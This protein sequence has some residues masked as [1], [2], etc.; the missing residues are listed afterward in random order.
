MIVGITGMYASGKDIVAAYLVEQGFE[1]FSLSDEIREEATRLGIKKT[2]D[3]LISLGNKL[4]EAF[5]PGILAERVCLKMWPGQKYV[6][7]SIR[8][9]AEVEELKKLRSF[10]LVAVIADVRQ[11]FKWLQERARDG[12]PK[13]FEAFVK[14][15]KIEQSSDPLKQQL[16][17]VQQMAKIVIRND[18]DL[19]QLHDKVRRMIHDLENS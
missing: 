9:P 8:N 15:E 4:R 5:G 12:E 14:K 16:H 19:T 11:R 13:T 7:T 10:V 17:A 2:R 18:S 3:N 6:V 1:H